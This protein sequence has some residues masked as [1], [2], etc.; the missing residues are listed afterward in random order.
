MGLVS[1]ILLTDI[2]HHGAPAPAGRVAYDPKVISDHEFHVKHGMTR[3]AYAERDSQWRRRD[4]EERAT[5]D[6]DSD[7]E[8][9]SGTSDSARHKFQTFGLILDRERDKLSALESRRSDFQGFVDAPARTQGRIS[10]AVAATTKWLLGG[11]AEEPAI[12]RAA[13]DS[14]LATAQHKAEAAAGAIAEV[15]RQI[16][17]AQIRVARL[18][19]AERGF[20]HD[21]VA[22]VAAD[23]IQTL[24]RKRGEVQALERLLDPLRRFG[25]ATHG[26]PESVEIKWRHTWQD[27]AN[28]LKADPSGD[29]SKML[30]RVPA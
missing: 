15:D 30:P 24:A 3:E 29:V 21:T 27:V 4:F 13:L 7:L 26:K 12:D 25:I 14:E 17:I 2:V 23:L 18:Q 10:A 22:E 11:S 20:L 1:N 16:E 5:A 6:L 28:V 8:A 19:E 9:I